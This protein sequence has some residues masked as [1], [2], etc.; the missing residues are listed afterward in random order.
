MGFVKREVPGLL[1]SIAEGVE[2]LL[3]DPPEMKVSR[4]QADRSFADTL[5]ISLRHDSQTEEGKV[6]L[7]LHML[8]GRD[9]WMR[10]QRHLLDA[11]SKA[12]VSHAWCIAEAAKGFEWFTSDHPLVRLQY[13][14]D[15]DFDVSGGW[16]KS[17]TN[18]FMPLSRRYL[19][20]CQ[21]GSESPERVRLTREQTSIVRRAIA[22]RAHRSVFALRPVQDIAA[23]HPRTVDLAVYRSEREQWTGWHQQQSEAEQTHNSLPRSLQEAI[24]AEDFQDEAHEQES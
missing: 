19:L 16:R 1:Q 15:G 12:A 4:P 11:V 21:V 17:G 2:G 6:Q 3:T 22:R 13:H 9:M 10:E 20:F 23:L 7:G 5:R 18:I 14:G 24:A 8:A